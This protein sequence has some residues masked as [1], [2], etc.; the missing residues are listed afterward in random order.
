MLPRI[1]IACFV[2]LSAGVFSPLL[3]A[4]EK[5][6][7]Q[8]DD[9]YRIGAVSEARVSPEGDWVAYTVTRE[10]PDEDESRSR[11]WMIPAGGGTAVAM[12]NED[13]SSWQPRWSPDG[14]YLSFLSKREDGE[15]QVW[16]LYRGGGEAQQISDTAQPVKSHDWSPD[17][18]RI[19]RVCSVRPALQSSTNSAEGSSPDSRSS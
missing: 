13:E 10:D 15:T 5:R 16:R 9:Y 18:S 6:L 2:A 7:L 11:I 3:F 4:Q 14:R 8:V 1:I 17:S 19:S 12:T